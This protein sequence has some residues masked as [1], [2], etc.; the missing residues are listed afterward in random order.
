MKPEEFIVLIQPA[1]H[2]LALRTGI[3][4]AVTVAQAAL[5]TGWLAHPIRHSVKAQDDLRRR[6]NGKGWYTDLPDGAES[7]NLF[8]IKAFSARDPFVVCYTREQLQNGNWITIP[9]RFRRYENWLESLQDHAAF[10]L[11]NPRYKPALAVGLKDPFEF[12]QQLQAC[13][14]A[15]DQRYAEKLSAIIRRYGLA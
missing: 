3:P 8:G 9:A 5:E 14:Y 7:Y 6:E 2:E 15:T 10:L 12:A 4:S 11:V 1:A 13:G